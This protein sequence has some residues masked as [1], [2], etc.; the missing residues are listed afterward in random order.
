[1]CLAD[2]ED[3]IVRSFEA[4][5]TQDSCFTC[6]FKR[7]GTISDSSKKQQYE[8]DYYDH[9][10]TSTRIVAPVSAVRPS[11]QAAHTHQEKDH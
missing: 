10:Q 3:F 9:A 4:H 11:W 8:K 2:V 7:E 6:S 5:S 1:V